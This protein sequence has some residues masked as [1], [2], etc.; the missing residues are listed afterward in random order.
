MVGVRDRLF[1]T[2]STA[3][4][5]AQSLVLSVLLLPLDLFMAVLAEALIR[6]RKQDRCQFTLRVVAKCK[7]VL[8]FRCSLSA[9]VSLL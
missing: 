6:Q 3:L 2:R 9:D 8:V 4:R 5:F 1:L 7:G